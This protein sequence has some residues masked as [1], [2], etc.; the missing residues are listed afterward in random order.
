MGSAY[1]C[2]EEENNFMNNY[3]EKKLIRTL[4]ANKLYSETQYR[5]KGRR[6]LH[7]MCNIKENT[8]YFKTKKFAED[9]SAWN[10]LSSRQ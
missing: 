2:R 1:N 3:K 7:V 4:I 5:R 10:F 6:K 9:R 8:S